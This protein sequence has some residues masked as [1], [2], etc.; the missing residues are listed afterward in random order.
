MLS[1][2]SSSSSC[3]CQ[4]KNNLENFELC[5]IGNK[6]E[7]L[8]PENVLHSKAV[9]KRKKKRKLERNCDNY[10]VTIARDESKQ[11]RQGLQGVS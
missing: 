5:Q 10:F 2:S 9:S 8:A 6:I 11:A 3:H 4:L 1:S 7:N